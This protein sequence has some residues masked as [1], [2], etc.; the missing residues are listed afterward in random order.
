MDHKFCTPD[1]PCAGADKRTLVVDAAVRLIVSEGLQCPMPAI[2]KEAGVA[3]GT[4]YT[5]F[6]S[7]E[8]MVEVVFKEVACRMW[9]S[10]FGSSQ[11]NTKPDNVE[12][13]LRGYWQALIRY[14]VAHPQYVLF[15]EYMSSSPYLKMAKKKEAFVDFQSYFKA[16]LDHG[17]KQGVVEK[18]PE[19]M[20]CFFIYGAIHSVILHAIQEGK[21]LSEAD[22]ENLTTLCWNT[23]RVR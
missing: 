4:I 10:L 18:F 19:D 1:K 17:N 23:V 15:L 13:A 8:E 20:L 3:V 12:A 22:V 14:L 7:K 21:E 16:V 2:A 9:Q 6:S 11:P 5:Y